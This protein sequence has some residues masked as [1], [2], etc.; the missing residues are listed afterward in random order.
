MAGLLWTFSGVGILTDVF[1]E[2]IEVITSR[3]KLVNLNGK[4]VSVL[5]RLVKNLLNTVLRPPPLNFRCTPPSPV[6]VTL[7]DTTSLLSLDHMPCLHHYASL[8]LSH[9]SLEHMPSLYHYASRRPCLSSMTTS[10]Y[11]STSTSTTPLDH[12]LPPLRHYLSLHLLPLLITHPAF[13]L[14]S[15]YFHP[16]YAST[17]SLSQLPLPTTHPAFVLPSHH[18]HPHY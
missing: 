3:E 9:L 16:H 6:A 5:V 13:V 15:P 17:P 4:Q 8:R 18:R 12:A 11:V 10:H 14:Q 2:A 7:A 1:M